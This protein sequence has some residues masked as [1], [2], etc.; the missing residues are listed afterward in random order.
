MLRSTRFLGLAVVL[1]ALASTPAAAQNASPVSLVPADGTTIDADAFPP[2]T[3]RGDGALAVRLAR[4]P[5][6]LDRCTPVSGNVVEVPGTPTAADPTLQAFVLPATLA[7]GLWYWQVVRRSPCAHGEIR[8]VTVTAGSGSGVEPELPSAPAAP[9]ALPR[10]SRA[11]I[12]LRI[13]AS[14][15][16]RMTLALGGVPRGVTRTR[17]ATLVRNS[18]ARWRLGLRGPADRVPALRDGHSDVGFNSALVPSQALGITIVQ[19]RTRVRVHYRCV[20]GRC[21][22]SRQ[23]GPT[24]VVERDVAFRADVPWEP[25][26][27]H[28]DLG[29]VDLETAI[30]HELGH[31]AGNA[32]HTALGCYDTPMVVG[33]ANG[34]WWRSPQDWS[35]RRCTGGTRAS[36]RMAVVRLDEQVVDAG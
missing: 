10:L 22:T 14:N 7:P 12:P 28:P 23:V 1:A 9:D 29:H 34:E 36:T 33:L 21:T 18:A 31:A 2:F 6:V 16:A 8:K 17:F 5:G 3:A 11:H 19:T 35:Y 4:T 20:A 26:P 13:G 27:A 25:G 30:I 15:H 24:Q 32:R